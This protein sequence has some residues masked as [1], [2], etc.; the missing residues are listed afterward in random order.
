MERPVSMISALTVSGC[1]ILWL[2]GASAAFS[3]EIGSSA[4]Q[5]TSPANGTIVNP[6]QAIGV[7]VTP[8]DGVRLKHV[9]IDPEQP[10][11]L[12]VLSDTPPFTF[13]ITP[14]IG[15]RLGDYMLTAWAD[16]ATGLTVVSNPISIDV[17]PDI[18]PGSITARP[19]HLY[20]ESQGEMLPVRIIASF[21]DGSVTDATES[22][23]VTYMSGNTALATV[24]ASGLTTAVSPGTTFITVAYGASPNLAVT[25]PISIQAA[26]ARIAPARLV[27]P[28][29]QA[30]SISGPQHVTVTNQ[31]S[32]PITI[33]A[34]S[35][36]GNFTESDDCVSAEPLPAGSSCT[37]TVVF[38]PTMP[39]P[40]SGTLTVADSFDAISPSISLSGTATAAIKFSLSATP[41][42]AT[43]S[44][45]HP[46]SYTLAVT[47]NGGF[48]QTV[49]VNCSGA[50]FGATCSVS[51]A[52]VTLNGSNASTATVTVSATAGGFTGSMFDVGTG[53]YIWRYALFLLVILSLLAMRKT[54]FAAAVMIVGLTIAC[55]NGSTANGS[56]LKSGTYM[57]TLQATAGNNT[58]STQVTLMVE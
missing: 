16:D 33:R 20:F 51:P 17:E 40:I 24:T 35:A 4:L 13:S 26:A 5:I 42:S 31:A 28:S 11:P 41:D 8:A 54:R 34:L 27:F 46:A 47:P 52:S 32:G 6:G 36:S 1:L 45:G 10:I 7:I 14:P 44:S 57:L 19:S 12:S 3:Q 43:L 48:N 39:G 38:A 9:F 21:P 15:A 58:Q 18:P 30:G 22:S 2:L 49:S 29:Q 55:G 53:T 37:A 56:G 25:V 23:N 50:P